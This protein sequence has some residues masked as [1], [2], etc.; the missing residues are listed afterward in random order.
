M[1]DQADVVVTS[2]TA[3]TPILVTG[4]PELPAKA[5]R[6]L[7]NFEA[8]KSRDEQCS[9]GCDILEKTAIS[10]RFDAERFDYSQHPCGVYTSL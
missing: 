6:P 7:A 9:V 1:T 3:A 5:R 8:V 10:L 4:L 2:W